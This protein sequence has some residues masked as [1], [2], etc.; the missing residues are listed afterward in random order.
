MRN[1][2]KNI[3]REIKLK[4]LNKKENNI[5]FVIIANKHNLNIK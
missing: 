4:K 5:S 2:K 3:N 1:E